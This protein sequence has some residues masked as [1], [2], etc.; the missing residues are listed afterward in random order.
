MLSV[1]YAYQ[2]EEVRDELALYFLIQVALAREAGAEIDFEEPGRQSV[3]NQ[4]VEAKQLEAVGAT[5]HVLGVRL[6]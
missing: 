5:L 1:D 4:N 2:I 3:V 6:P